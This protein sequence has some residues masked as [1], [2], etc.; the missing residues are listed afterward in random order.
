MRVTHLSLKDFRSY[1]E[2]E[3]ELKPKQT[4]F[5]GDN[6]E[7]KTNIIEAITYLSL[8]SSH[9][10]ASDAPLVK[11]GAERAYIRARVNSEDRSQLIE[12]EIN[13]NKANRAKV[14]SNPVRSQ[15][16]ILGICTS[17][18]FSPE[19]LDLVRGDP[20][21]RRQF[22]DHLIT[23]KN[24]R[25]AGVIAD[26]ERALKQRNALLKS[27][28]SLTALEP[29]DNH[30]LTF[31]AEVIAGRI[32]LINEL[33]PFFIAAYKN[34]A[35]KKPAAISYKSSV[36]G[37]SSDRESNKKL[38]ANKLTEVRDQERDRGITLVGPHRDDLQL[39]LGD[40]PVKGYASHGE[41]WSIALSLRLAS[42]QLLQSTGAE[43]ILI[44][45]DVF[46]ELDQARREKL[47]QLANEAE[48]TLITVAVESDLPQ[49]IVGE[50]YR[51]KN[52]AV[53]HE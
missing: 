34:L 50:K 10:V 9:R 13:S 5:I 6:G 16:E 27:R 37:L 41:S 22:L 35:E 19:D 15:R 20:S 40:H 12:L 14:N 2:L 21:E 28:A 38:L 31:G 44:L 3:L 48:Q 46:S 17:I 52:G 8:L 51:V 26:Y 45:D 11:L 42:F 18:T 7:G 36:E 32:D 24:P 53:K 1:S 29:W 4:I 33:S 23:Q 43:P 25:L 39:Y 49:S 47:V 30:I